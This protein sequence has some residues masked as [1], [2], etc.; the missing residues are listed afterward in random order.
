MPT[1]QLPIKKRFGRFV[2]Q[3]FE[4][5]KAKGAFV[6]RALYGLK[7]AGAAFRAHLADC[8]HRLGLS[9]ALLILMY[10]WNFPQDLITTFQYYTY[11][12]LYFDDVLVVSH[13]EMK[14][15]KQLDY[16]FRMKKDSMGDPDLCL[17]CKNSGMLDYLIVSTV[18][19]C[20]LAS[21]SKKQ[22]RGCKSFP[23][24]RRMG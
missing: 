20:H 22:L 1:L 2:D 14:V 4:R 7:S 15:L 19:H 18:G 17:V 16:F 21:M 3:S 5:I 23:R 8:M 11:V 12:L 24:L 10:G 6:V 9:H 13:D